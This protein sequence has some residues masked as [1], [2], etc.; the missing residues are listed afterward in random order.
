MQH[1]TELRDERAVECVR[2][3][4]RAGAAQHARERERVLEHVPRPELVLCA[5]R[6]ERREQWQLL[7][8]DR[9]HHLWVWFLYCDGE[10]VATPDSSSSH[11]T[12]MKTGR[13]SCA[14]CVL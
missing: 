10:G 1:A 2:V 6:H 14:F 11:I 3:W 4:T 8:E 12:C 7:L 5:V 9:P 13:Q